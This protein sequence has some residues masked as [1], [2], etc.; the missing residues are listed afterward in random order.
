MP[1]F[2]MEATVDNVLARWDSARQHAT[3]QADADAEFHVWLMRTLPTLARELGPAPDEDL[4]HCMTVGATI[5]RCVSLGRFDDSLILTDWLVGL[6]APRGDGLA[7]QTISGATELY[8][9]AALVPELH[10]HATRSLRRMA[11]LI[12]PGGEAE[13]EWLSCKALMDLSTLLIINRDV[14]SHQQRTRTSIEVCDEIIERWQ[15]S[16]EV[17]LRVNVAATMVNKAINCMEIGEESEAR[18]TYAR[19]VELFTADIADTGNIKL[20]EH[21][22]IARHAL[23]VLDTVRIPE[24]NFKT[25]Y[26]EAMMRAARRTGRYDPEGLVGVPRDYDVHAIRLAGQI[27][28]AT[29]NLVRRSA[30]SGD[31]TVLLLRNFDLTETSFVSSDP[32][33]V[34]GRS[35]P[36]GHTRIIRYTDGQRLLN[37]IAE[38]TDVVQVANTNAAVL[39]IDGQVES[40]LGISKRLQR[41]LYLPDDGWLD[42]VRVLIVLAERVVV[43]AAEKTP[44]LLRELELIKELGRADDTLVLLE[45]PLVGFVKP[46]AFYGEVPPPGETFTPDDPALTGFPTIAHAKDVASVDLEN[47]SL[48]R[49]LTSPVIALG[50]RP[51]P[52]RV[53]RIR[54]RLDAAR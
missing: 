36:D 47:C 34:F 14:H 7:R 5:D 27:H 44:A 39:G 50:Q 16:S 30:C 51:V 40:L 24:P 10:E 2:D 19:I 22:Y 28:H 18:R 53:A 49:E 9:D 42:I 23:D 4:A 48:L 13:M 3:R 45:E 15:S 17:W 35:D 37:R 38:I 41:F 54:R 31:P 29:T 21:V 1:E 32:H 26:L 43:W 52:E 25:G 6:Y 20:S 8:R 11:E 46:D 12:P 33:P